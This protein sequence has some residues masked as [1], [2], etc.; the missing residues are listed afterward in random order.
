MHFCRLDSI[1]LN[2]CASLRIVAVQQHMILQHQADRASFL[3][4]EMNVGWV[5]LSNVKVVRLLSHEWLWKMW[6]WVLHR[7]LWKWWKLGELLTV[8]KVRWVLC[9][10]HSDEGW[11]S[12]PWNVVKVTKVGWV[13]HEML[14]KWWRL[15]EFSSEM[16]I[17]LK[18]LVHVLVRG[19]P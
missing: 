1:N 4:K 11:V 10:A 9:S 3:L 15:G 7:G 13:L 18:H 5:L 17:D 6:G 2:H 19:I 8:T 16:W 14:W 12:S